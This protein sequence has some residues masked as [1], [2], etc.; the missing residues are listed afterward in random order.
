MAITTVSPRIVGTGTSGVVSGAPVQAT[1]W[2]SIVSAYDTLAGAGSVLIPWH[3]PMTSIAASGSKT[4]QYRVWPRHAATHRAWCVSIVATTST[5]GSA[6]VTLGGGT[7]TGFL[8]SDAAP[9]TVRIIEELSSQSASESTASLTATLGA[10]TGAKVVGVSCWELPRPSIAM[11]TGPA[12]DLTASDAG[13]DQTVARPGLPV[14]DD[15]QGLGVGYISHVLDS[16]RDETRRPGLIA[17]A[18]FASST[19]GTFA[20]VFAAPTVVLGRFLYRGQLS[21]T[22]QLASFVRTSDATTSGELRF[23]MASGAVTT[24]GFSGTTATTL[25]RG[26]IAIDAEDL[27]ASDGRRSSRDDTCTVELRRSAGAGTVYVDTLT[28]GEGNAVAVA[29]VAPA[30]GIGAV[31]SRKALGKLPPRWMFPTRRKTR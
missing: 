31:G 29:A 20:A 6:T 7:S 17:G 12:F 3:A 28:G 26:Q 2:A 22:M 21:S 15:Y 14:A 9:R 30:V 16:L 5:P 19:S 1:E 25:I 13:L 24:L 11:P 10:T 27:T 8:F 23:T 4:Y 18:P